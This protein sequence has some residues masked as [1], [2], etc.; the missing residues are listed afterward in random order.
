MSKSDT[1]RPPRPGNA[2]VHFNLGNCMT[3]LGQM[4][5]AVKCYDKAIERDPEQPA[6]YRA[7]EH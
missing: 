2:F 1:L 6:F 7:R 3:T 5:K 4:H